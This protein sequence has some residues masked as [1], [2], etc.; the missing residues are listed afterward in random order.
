MK[1]VIVACILTALLLSGCAQYQLSPGHIGV[2]RAQQLALEAA[3]VNAA[4]AVFTDAALESRDGLEYYQVDFTADGGTYHYDIDAL[5]GVVIDSTTPPA[6]P[7]PKQPT[8][9]EPQRT[10]TEITEEEARE[11]ALAHAGL[12]A[13]QVSFVKSGLD[14]DDGRKT[15]D[16]E[17]YTTDHVEYDYEIDPTTGE[18]L[19]CDYDAEYYAPPASTAP[20]SGTQDGGTITADAAKALAIAQV[21]GATLADIREFSTDYDD[22]RLEYEGKLYYEHME[23][24]FEIDGYSG[25][26]LSWEVESIFD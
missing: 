12:R 6:E 1:K 9:A 2:E 15:Y 10:S 5:T 18:V 19:H 20:P 22:G 7:E 21:P 24:E 23:Y 14:W 26:I 13:D 8:P 16:V 17:F 4:Q 25:A 11:I 3:G